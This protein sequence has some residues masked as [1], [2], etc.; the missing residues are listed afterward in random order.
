MALVV[1][2]ELIMNNILID[3]NNTIS[4]YHNLKWE[5][6]LDLHITYGKPFYFALQLKSIFLY[7]DQLL[8]LKYCNY[9]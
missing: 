7:H 9:S 8:M 4:F 1:P 2:L 6:F 5:R 3:K